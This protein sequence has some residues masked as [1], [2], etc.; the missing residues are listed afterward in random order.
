LAHENDESKTL[1]IFNKLYLGF[2]VRTC[3]Q[4]VKASAPKQEEQARNFSDL[5]IENIE[6]TKCCLSFFSQ[7][8]KAKASRR[9]TSIKHALFRSSI[10]VQ[11]ITLSAE[12]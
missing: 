5:T 2:H 6:K 10:K 9:Q 12:K 11:P 7:N 3:R 1:Q 8:Q 4:M